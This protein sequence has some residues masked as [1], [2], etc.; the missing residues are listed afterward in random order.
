M[1]TKT[2]YRF[3]LDAGAYVGPVTLDESDL[4]PLE[5]DVYLI[6][7]DCLEAVPPTVPEG[8]R[9]I[10]SNA[11]WVLEPIPEV[12]PPVL[13]SIAELAETVRE[14]TR[15]LRQGI[16]SIIDGLQISAVVVGNTADAQAIEAV[17]V[18]LRDITKLPLE[19]AADLDA[20]KAMV[21]ARYW[22]LVTPA[23][24][25]VKQAFSEALK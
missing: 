20:M 24:L 8:M 9:A 13:P 10:A 25:G 18:G 3:D 15:V 22:E 21:K 19:G 5:D 16:F 4:S 11:S 14:G 6:P 17:K 2:V 1:N 7:G 12:P 23:P